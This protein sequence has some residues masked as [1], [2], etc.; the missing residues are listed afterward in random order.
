MSVINTSSRSEDPT[1]KRFSVIF[2]TGMSFMLMPQEHYDVLVT[3]LSYYAEFCVPG[4]TTA[5]QI[6]L[7]FPTLSFVILGHA[8]DLEVR[9]CACV[10][11]FDLR[12]CSVRAFRWH[13]LKS[14]E[15]G[16]DI[17]VVAVLFLIF[18]SITLHLQPSFYMH[19]DCTVRFEPSN[20]MTA[21]WILGALD[22]SRDQFAYN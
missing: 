13:L 19:T 5:A 1:L 17:A 6:N 3:V 2:D 4:K 8:F 20:D 16:F 21:T 18:Y 10:C 9:F 7:I 22:T 12:V 11:R 14:L 15:R